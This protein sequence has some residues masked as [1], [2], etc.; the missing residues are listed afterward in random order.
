MQRWS[1]QLKVRLGSCVRSYR[2]GPDTGTDCVKT[3]MDLQDRIAWQLMKRSRWTQ[4]PFTTIVQYIYQS[5][6]DDT[7]EQNEWIPPSVHGRAIKGTGNTTICG[8]SSSRVPILD[9]TNLPNSQFYTS[10]IKMVR[11]RHW[12]THTH[13]AKAAST[14]LSA[15]TASS[16]Y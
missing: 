9:P 11:T 16:A 2:M 4:L 6:A 7:I 5:T 1:T 12:H 15:T 14:S 3:R 13:T 10:V 8:E